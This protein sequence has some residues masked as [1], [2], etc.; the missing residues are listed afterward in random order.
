MIFDAIVIF[1]L[2]FSCVIAFLRGFI[3]EAL[4][5]IGLFVGIGAAYVFGPAMVPVVTR[6]LGENA[7]H[8]HKFLGV[9][10]GDQMALVCAYSIVFFPTLIIISVASYFLSASVRAMGLGAIDRTA[11][12]LFGLARALVMLSILYLPL[13]LWTAK[14]DRDKMG[15]LADSHTRVYVETVSG[16]MVNAIPP[17]MIAGIKK[18]A[19]RAKEEAKTA[20]ERLQDIDLLRKDKGAAQNGNNT[21]V[22]AVPQP[23]PAAQ[24]SPGTGYQDEQRQDMGKLI[25]KGINQ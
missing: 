8:A 12:V 20:R 22:Q 17:T 25:N 4:T 21:D 13:Y 2:L 16:W 9:L 18:D 19:D 7:D 1:A 5:I 6:W 15:F 10:H 11:G 23:A 14:E 3:R 24:P